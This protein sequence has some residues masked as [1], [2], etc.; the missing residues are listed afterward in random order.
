[1][2]DRI[3]MNLKEAFRYQN[4]LDNMMMQAQTSIQNREHS[5]KVTKKHLRSKV[6][7]DAEDF[8]EVVEVDEFFHNDD[9][10]KFMQWLVDEKLSLSTAINKAKAS[11]DFD[12]DAA[13]AQNK[14]RQMLHQ[15]IKHMLR[16]TPS[17]RTEQGYGYKFNV[18][19]NQT[20]YKYDVE[21]SSEEAYDK[22]QA[23]TVM[24]E[25]I[26]SA[27]EISSKIDAAKINTIVNYEPRFDVNDSFIDVMTSFAESE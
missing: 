8:E 19:G 13:T 1:M 15:S 23:K 25:A 2:E 3:M 9:V 12:I 16:W 5:L 17:K 24:R 6:N 4:F 11:I 27:D 22:N 20:Q 21:V 26:K 18:E 14:Y 10:I 7:S